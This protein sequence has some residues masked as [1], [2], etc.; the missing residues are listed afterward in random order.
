MARFQ[1]QEPICADC[2]ARQVPGIPL[3]EL[4]SNLV[5]N[6]PNRICCPMCGTTSDKAIDDGL[7]GC[8]LCYEALDDTVWRHFGITPGSWTKSPV[9]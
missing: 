6:K 9:G 2:M 8:P 7:V 3:R 1:V 4:S 5:S